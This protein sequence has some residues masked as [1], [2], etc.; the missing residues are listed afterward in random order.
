[1]SN[2]FH[3]FYDI[4]LTFTKEKGKKELPEFFYL[5]IRKTFAEISKLP[6]IRKTFF[7]S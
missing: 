1:M 4:K 5:V 6:K 7:T 3:F 2:Y